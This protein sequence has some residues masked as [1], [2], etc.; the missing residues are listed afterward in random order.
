VLDLV[1]FIPPIAGAVVGVV[2]KYLYD[3]YSTNRRFKKELEDNDFIDVTG[4]WYAAWQTSVDGAELL[5]TEHVK[6][7]QKGKTLRMFNTEKSPENPKA[8]YLWEGQLQFFQGRSAMGWY[9]PKK[10]ENNG[11]RGILYMTHISQRKVFIGKWVGAAYDGELVTG[12]VVIGK[13]RTSAR[14]ELE[15]FVKKHP[16]N[17]QLISYK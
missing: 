17:I 1:S 14:L 6:L 2:L 3:L 5:N 13:D 11:S 8:G 16:Q 12:F 10:G 15:K 9:L 4:E 7:I